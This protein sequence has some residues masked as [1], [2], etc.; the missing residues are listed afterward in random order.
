VIVLL[1]VTRYRVRYQV[2]LGRP[3]SFFERLVLEAVNEGQSSLDALEATFRIHRR[4]LIESIVTL[5]QAGWVAFDTATHALVATAAGTKAIERPGELPRNIT[6]AER[7]DYVVGERV[8]GQLAKGGDVTYVAKAELRQYFN[9]VATLPKSDLPHPVEGGMMVPLLRRYDGEWIRWCGPIDIVR[10]GADFVVVDVDTSTGTV[11][12]IPAK[13][14]PLL[15]ED[16]LDRARSKER[17]LILAG[18]PPSDSALSRLVRKSTAFEDAEQEDPS[19]WY[20][21]DVEERLVVDARQHR[22]VLTD[23]LENARSY[24]CIVSG[25]MSAA[26]VHELTDAFRA[27]IRRGVLIDVIWGT[28]RDDD[29]HRQAIKLLKKIEWDSQHASAKGRLSTARMASYSHA[30]ILLADKVDDLEAIVGSHDW[31]ASADD[32]TRMDLSLTI[33][34]SGPLAQLARIVADL[35]AADERLATG[36]GVTRLRHA[37]AELDRQSAEAAERQKA[38]KAEMEASHP[39]IASPRE[40]ERPSGAV[41]VRLIVGREHHAL[42]SLLSRDAQQ[43]LILICH[44]WGADSQNAF[45]YLGDALQRGCRRVEIRYGIEGHRDGHD[46]LAAEFLK[47]GGVIQPT[48]EMHAKLL[49]SDD[50]TVAL[51]SFD[52]LSPDLDRAHVGAGEVGF[53]LRGERVASTLLQN[54]RIPLVAAPPPLAAHYIR[55]F[56]ITHVRSVNHVDW[57][58]DS[59]DDAA[60]WHVLIGDNGSGK[61]SVL[62]SLALALMGEESAH[63][64]RQDWSTWL[65]GAETSAEVSVAIEHIQDTSPQNVAA[66]DTSCKVALRWQRSGDGTTVFETIDDNSE[67]V[68]VGYGPF[69][70]FTGDVESERQL[71]SLPRLARHISLFD[72][73]V[74]LTETLSW[75]RDLR[76]R[77]LEQDAEATLLLER[78]TTLVNE[79]DLLPSGPRLLPVRPDAIFFRDALGYDYPIEELS[80][81]YRSV[82]SLTFDIVRHLSVA[83]GPARVFDAERTDIVSAPGIVL[84]DEIDAHLHP[85]WQRTIGQWF[86]TRFPRVQ[87]IV[88]THSPLVC[89]AAEVGTVFRLPTTLDDADHG[90][91]LEGD[92]R[93]RLVYGNILEAYSTGAFGDNVTRSDSSAEHMNRLAI[94]N[95]KELAAGLL[96]E[97]KA[98]QALLRAA[99]PTIAHTITPVGHT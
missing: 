15:R 45:R 51:T 41:R 37:A 64:L 87:F 29:D 44:R 80:D 8:Y 83:H 1:P 2:A 53:V 5:M 20:L 40:V 7:S 79:C 74:A 21:D 17:Q 4:V 76:F 26:R 13:W 78:L 68:S 27:A 39:E 25:R 77:S 23:W 46:A 66:N 70:R 57:K 42:L 10:D 95:Q 32:D 73:R 18:I 60:G 52:W 85:S 75:L 43:R 61:T 72:E 35:A 30:K 34:E 11:T 69:R 24:I 82:L 84:I 14:E 58:I 49:A 63:A 12:G 67:V 96:P 88:T 33:R 97:E 89:Q 56:S 91:M 98:E 92:A 50:D 9:D 81:G 22:L 38:L 36:A 94:L 31:L 65:R 47:L 93:A 55:A 62:R 90:E 48:P 86:R 3:F 28:A 59:G 19:E 99:L 16:L 71:A 6:V 54:I